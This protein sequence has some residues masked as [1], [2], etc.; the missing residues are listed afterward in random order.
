[1]SARRALVLGIS[2]QDGALLARQLHD[3]GY[4]VHGTS[5][6][7]HVGIL[8]NLARVGVGEHV[9]AHALAPGDMQGTLRV[10]ETVEPHEIYALAG[11]SSV[12][13]SFEQP[14]PTFDSIAVGTQVL[15]EAVRITK[16]PTRIFNAGSGE[17]FGELAGRADESCCLRP[18]SPYA[19]AKASAHWLV[20]NY[21]ESY[22]LFACTGFLFNHESPL[23]PEQF[24]TQK[25]I[26]A[27]CRIAGG[28]GERLKLGNTEV[29]RDWGWAPEYVDAMWRM[30]QQ[31]E[32][33]DFVIAT[34]NGHSLTEFV[35]LSFAALDLDWRDHVDCDAG[36]RRPTDIPYSVG[37]PSGAS[38]KLRWESRLTLRE[39][40][41]EMIAARN[42]GAWPLQPDAVPAP[43]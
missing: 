34:G 32:P 5:R 33:R 37:D 35:E 3:R 43:T 23:R 20:A 38:A 24:V 11:Q 26:A 28:S 21:R 13:L 12:G 9:V 14:G 8:H 15:L 25:I 19:V 18:G 42:G 6:G 4:A 36:L 40:I 1:M 2:G 10:L 16:L 7:A 30:L 41:R 31:P 39:V 29:I 27:A 17:C 22:G